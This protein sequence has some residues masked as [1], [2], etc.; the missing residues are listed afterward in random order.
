M[1]NDKFIYLRYYKKL[2]EESSTVQR[3]SD[4]GIVKRI[5]N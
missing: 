4:L 5:T 1:K 3:R 2:E